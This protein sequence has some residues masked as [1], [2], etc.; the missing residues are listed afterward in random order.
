[1][2]NAPDVHLFHIHMLIRTVKSLVELGDGPWSLVRHVKMRNFGL[3]REAVIEGM[4]VE[5]GPQ[6][7]PRDLFKNELEGRML[8]GRVMPG[9]VDALG[10]PIALLP[11]LLIAIHIA[12]RDDLGGIARSRGR[13]RQVIGLLE[14]V[15][16]PD[17]RLR[18]DGLH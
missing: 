16:E 6:E 5:E 9:L 14:V 17:D 15:F 11:G 1:M 13:D 18:R 12:R 2:I 8:D 7:L 4:G 3:T 10:D